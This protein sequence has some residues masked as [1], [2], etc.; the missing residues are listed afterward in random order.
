M[1]NY[2]WLIRAFGVLV[3]ENPPGD[4]VQFGPRTQISLRREILRYV[5]MTDHRNSVKVVLVTSAYVP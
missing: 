5:T 1:V 3:V 2:S 4:D